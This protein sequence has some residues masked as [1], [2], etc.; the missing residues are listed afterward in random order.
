MKTMSARLLAVLLL[1]MAP[2]SAFAA[3]ESKTEADV[4]YGHKDGMALTFDVIKP[5]KPN[6]A[7]ILWLQSGGWYSVW[8]DSKGWAGILKPWLDK[9]FTMFIVRHGSAPKYTVPEA[10]EDVRRSVL[11]STE[12][13]ALGSQSRT[14]RRDGRQRGRPSGADAGYDRR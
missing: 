11:H 13:E 8:V 9:G 3:S 12:G 2:C 14:A 6:G 4:V 5:A 10:I 1:G 7:A